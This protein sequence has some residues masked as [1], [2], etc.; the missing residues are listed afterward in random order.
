MPSIER[1]DLGAWSPDYGEHQNPGLLAARGVIPW[2]DGSYRP[3]GHFVMP[4]A[5]ADHGGM[6]RGLHVHSWLAQKEAYAAVVNGAS[7]LV[8]KVAL[9]AGN[10]ATSTS[11]IGTRTDVT[12]PGDWGA[13]TMPALGIRFASYGRFVIAVGDE[14]FHP[15]IRDSTGA[16]SFGNMVPS[17]SSDRPMARFVANSGPRVTLAYIKHNS[18]AER[19]RVGSDDLTNPDLVWLSGKNDATYFST[20]TTTGGTNAWDASKRSEF[21]F[22]YDDLGDITGCVSLDEGFT[23]VFKRRGIYRFDH[24]ASGSVTDSLV[25]LSTTTG[26]LFPHSLVAVGP[27]V[28]FW[29][30]MGGP[31]RVSHSSPPERIAGPVETV[32]LDT[33]YVDMGDYSSSDPDHPGDDYIVAQDIETLF[34]GAGAYRYPVGS[35]DAYSRTVHWIFP[36]AKSGRYVDLILQVETGRYSVIDLTNAQDKPSGE[37]KCEIHWT[38]S[39]PGLGLTWKPST[40]QRF[41]QVPR[42]LLFAFRRD[43]GPPIEYAL[44]Y[45]WPSA[46]GAGGFGYLLL[47]N[48]TFRTAFLPFDRIVRLKGIRPVYSRKVAAQ[49]AS[50]TLEADI[51][52]TVLTKNQPGDKPV[53]SEKVKVR[54]GDGTTDPHAFYTIDSAAGIYHAL[55]VSF[56]SDDFTTDVPRSASTVLTEIERFE[57]S[58]TESSGGAAA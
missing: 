31:S 2:N 44:T 13:F 39:S 30:Q 42:D 25:L 40:P 1:Y 51:H 29:D 32:L 12:G 23:F 17:G 38:A 33:D 36:S 43:D 28:Y 3:V 10:P 48:A 20:P 35:Y 45:F 6:I 24:N 52:V 53:K 37:R 41:S 5:A 14:T 54:L 16:A 55:E 21:F 49:D 46:E 11:G 19:D 58:V 34:S 7:S 56:I 50:P 8:D 57:V 22:L 15:Q 27:Y 26:T 18:T 4:G 47:D 9:I